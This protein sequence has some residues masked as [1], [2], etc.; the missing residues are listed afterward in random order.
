MV[1][2]LRDPQDPGNEQRV[3]IDPN[4]VR[5]IANV[6]APRSDG[7]NG[8]RFSV[9]VRTEFA[10]PGYEAFIYEFLSGLNNFREASRL[11]CF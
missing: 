9:L 7:P 10:V 6:A 4:L 5:H 1:V 8:L 11:L 3:Y 2:L